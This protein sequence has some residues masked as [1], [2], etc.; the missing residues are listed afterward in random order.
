MKTA[1]LLSVQATTNM[2]TAIA[3]SCFAHSHRFEL[4]RRVLLTLIRA[5]VVIKTDCNY[6]RRCCLGFFSQSWIHCSSG[7][8]WRGNRI[9]YPRCSMSSTGCG[10]WIQDPVIQDPISAMRFGGPLPSQHRANISRRQPPSNCWRRRSSP[11]TLFRLGHVGRG[12]DDCDE[13]FNTRQPCI[14]R[15]CI[16]NV[17][18][19]VFLSQ[20]RFVTVDRNWRV[21]SDIPWPVAHLF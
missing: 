9:A 18:W 20:S 21:F 7:V 12:T 3:R 1:W 15:R 14:P 2:V 6:R 17:E 10:S 4:F 13:P 19:L 16:K 11:S 5:L 8:F